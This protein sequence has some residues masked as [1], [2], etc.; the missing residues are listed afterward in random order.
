MSAILVEIKCYFIVVWICI[1]L[2]SMIKKFLAICISYFEE[3]F[4]QV[5]F[6][7]LIGLFAFWLLNCRNS[8]YILE[9]AWPIIDNLSHSPVR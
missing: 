9:I 3:M 5:L 6:P 4:T 2:M 8:L 1:F 7:F